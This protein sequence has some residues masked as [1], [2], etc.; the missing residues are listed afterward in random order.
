M[1]TMYDAVNWEAIPAEA[2]AVAGYVDGAESEWPAEAWQ[3][4]TAAKI[5]RHICTTGNNVGD[6]LDVE[7]GDATNETAGPWIAKRV[8]AG[9]VEEELWLYTELDNY[10]ALRSA[11]PGF[12]GG[13]WIA[14]W[15]GEEHDV[16]GAVA[17]QWANP[18]HNS[19]GDFDLSHLA[20]P[21]PAPSDPQPTAGAGAG[22]GDEEMP[23]YATNTA[24]TGFVV[25]SDLSG[26][27]GLPDAAD[28]A[29]LI[30]TGLYKEVHLTDELL[31]EIPG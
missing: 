10:A 23:L 3:K 2:E 4:F 7:N 20:V 6:T 30:E 19:G 12:T 24:G 14:D 5:V 25:A 8:G 1:T 16:E 28:A 9:A 13:F 29:A 21:A 27:R 18:S 26:K 15:T 22:T 31:N 11:V 17:T